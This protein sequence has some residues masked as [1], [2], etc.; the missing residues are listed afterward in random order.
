M[1]A[2]FLSLIS[3]GCS[4]TGPKKDFVDGK[5]VEVEKRFFTSKLKQD[6][7]EIRRDSFEKAMEENIGPDIKA[8]SAYWNR[9]PAI[10]MLLGGPLLVIHG[11]ATTAGTYSPE[12]QGIIVAGVGITALGGLL[13]KLANN[14]LEDAARIYNESL[15][16]NRPSP[17]PPN[18]MPRAPESRSHKAFP[19]LS[20]R[21]NF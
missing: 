9:A 19:A 14:D 17:P 2:L 7:Q 18:L 15:D 5:P 11:L 8:D 4:T 20:F 13:L 21:L 1:A 10:A 16:P 3:F 6:G 12:G